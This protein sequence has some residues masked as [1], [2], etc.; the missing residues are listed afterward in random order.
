MKSQKNASDLKKFSRKPVDEGRERSPEPAQD[1]PASPPVFGVSTEGGKK[2]KRPLGSSDRILVSL[3]L[4]RM[5]WESI[6]SFAK[7][8]GLSLQDLALSG[9]AVL[10]KQKG[11]IIGEKVLR[12]P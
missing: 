3:R 8:E 11:L 7:A 12:Q 5:Q 10:F 2:A 1:T 6:H 4:T 9:I